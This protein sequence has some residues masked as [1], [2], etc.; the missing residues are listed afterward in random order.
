MA[1][2]RTPNGHVMTKIAGDP[3]TLDGEVTRMKNV[4]ATIEKLSGMLSDIHNK[5]NSQS[6]KID[7]IRDTA[8][9][10]GEQLE[11]VK[12]LYSDT[13]WAL[14]EYSK[15]LHT[16]VKNGNAAYNSAVELL[17][18]LNAAE[19]AHNTAVSNQKKLDNDPAPTTPEETAAAKTKSENAGTAVSNTASTLSTKAEE[20]LG[21]KKSWDTAYDDLNT[22]AET[23]RGR[24]KK[25]IDKSPAKDS[26]WDNIAGFLSKISSILGWIALACVIV[27]IFA[28][29]PLALALLAVATA[30]TAVKLLLD[31]VLAASGK[32]SWKDVALDAI[33]L[34]P[35]GKLLAPGT[36]L[37]SRLPAAGKDMLKVF[38]NLRPSTWREGPAALQAAITKSAT[39][40]SGKLWETWAAKTQ[41]VVDSA[42]SRWNV[43]QS[44][45]AGGSAEY[46]KASYILENLAQRN[47]PARDAIKIAE[48]LTNKP[49]IGLGLA[50]GGAT[51]LGI[52]DTGYGL[53][54][55][56]NWT[57]SAGTDF[58]DHLI[59]GPSDSDLK[60]R[61]QEA[62]MLVPAQQLPEPDWDKKY[63]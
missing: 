49:G 21:Y 12:G 45:K 61:I 29:G 60:A 6:Q 5:K 58:I 56:E 22:A 8:G 38:S 44:L 30:V 14:G 62:P 46:A 26:T 39:S 4:G 1:D 40:R 20:M 9:E 51:T 57:V 48:M 17:P 47:V 25:I 27:A 2:L 19:T 53:A 36:K 55:G 15:Q 32:G 18:H 59:N 7:T 52:A 13:G 33:A 3:D 35:F 43:W 24:I 37:A 28:T 31:T 23:A 41:S 50:Y 42:P 16:S 54:N 63:Q 11:R 10:A 34:I